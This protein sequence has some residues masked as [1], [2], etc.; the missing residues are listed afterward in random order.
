[1]SNNKLNCDICPI[2]HRAACAALS[3]DERQQLS[4]M[5]HH[6]IVKRGETVFFAGEKNLSCATLVTGA[7]KI[8]KMDREGEE[9]ILSII[10]PAGYVGE[11]FAPMIHHDV[12]ALSDSSLC[13]FSNDQYE[14]A[15]SRFPTLSTA[16]LRRT[17]EDLIAARSMIDLLGKRSAKVRIAG[18]IHAFAMAASH[19]PCHPSLRFDFPLSRGEL[20]NILG[21][22]I[23]TVSRQLSK[24]EQ[25]AVIKK[26]GSR[27]IEICNMP[28]LET[29]LI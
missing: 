4:S 25:A 28:Q 8:T 12:V 20:A 21:L 9:H 2:K 22:T 1:M 15:L 19:S 16:L 23:E 26:H 18:I 17:S 29:L 11:M 14:I 10:H 7:L 3:D 24:L 13:V 6:R 27:G 5:G